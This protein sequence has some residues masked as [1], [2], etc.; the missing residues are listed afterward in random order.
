VALSEIAWDVFRSSPLIGAG[1]GTFVGIVGSSH[2]FR[3][4][5]GDPLDSHG[6]LQKLA[7]ETGLLGLAAFLWVIAAFFRTMLT[8]IRSLRDE[9]V[10]RVTVLLTASAL[11]AIMYQLFNTNYWTGKMWLPVGI[12]LASISA[13]TSHPSHEK[14]ANPSRHA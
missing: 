8:H 14:T 7:A 10:R 11:G 5:F 3:L 12:A 13:L 6:V 1:A 9:N 4:E 2:V